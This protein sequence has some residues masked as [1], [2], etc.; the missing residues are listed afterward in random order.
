MDILR[1]WTFG[2]AAFIALDFILRL[3]LPFG[4]LMA[5]NLLCPLLAGVVAAAVH[6]WT[7]KG[8]WVRHAIAVLGAPVFLSLYYALFTPWNLSTGIL[9]DIATGAVF[10]LAAAIGAVIVHLVERFVLSADS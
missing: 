6:L 4:S 9:M 8:G 3:I 1:S 5:L 10:V 7:G 2:A